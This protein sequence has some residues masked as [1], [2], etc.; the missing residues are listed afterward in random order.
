MCDYTSQND[1]CRR[2]DPAAT[3]DAGQQVNQAKLSL[4]SPPEP[5]TAR[6]R[7]PTGVSASLR[8]AAKRRSGLSASLDKLGMTADGRGGQGVMAKR[9]NRWV[10][11]PERKLVNESG[12]P[13][14]LETDAPGTLDQMVE[15]DSALADC[16]W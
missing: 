8:L 16:N 11:M 14:A 12:P 10:T 5:R 7:L 6:H 1:I 3:G 13:M 4:P 15:A 9:K 2:I